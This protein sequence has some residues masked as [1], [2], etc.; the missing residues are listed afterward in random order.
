M[1]F[2]V[3]PISQNCTPIAIAKKG[4]NK[5]P[6]SGN[7]QYLHK[8]VK[9]KTTDERGTIYITWS[10]AAVGLH[11][12]IVNGALSIVLNSRH[13]TDEAGDRGW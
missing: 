7:A 5:Y 6:K 8:R 12:P 9:C 3:K 11:I 1:T 10:M 2:D 4:L 13:Q